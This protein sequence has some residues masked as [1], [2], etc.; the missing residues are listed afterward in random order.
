MNLP[1]SRHCR[2][3][4]AIFSI[5]LSMLASAAGPVVDKKPP[6]VSINTPPDSKAL[7]ISLITVTGKA[8][9][10]VAVTNV[11]CN[12]N[13]QG[14]ASASTGNGWSNW[15]IN[16]ALG[17]DTNTLLVYA[18]DSSGNVSKTEKLKLTYVIAPDSLA[19]MTIT[20]TRPDSSVVTENFGTNTFS[21]DTAV[22]TYA[23]KKDGAAS[24][25]LSLKYTAPPSATPASNNVTVVLRF[26]D[27]TD[28]TFV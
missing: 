25:K 2:G 12:L 15:W 19:G 26:T 22:G 18:V 10:N 5:A 1:R 24:G 27:E 23:Y 17:P 20:V 3:I 13:G 21:E 28:G 4:I 9:D 7:A 16:L 14:W 6:T 8:K 11:L